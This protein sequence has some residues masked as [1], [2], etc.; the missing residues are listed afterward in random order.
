[1]V[2]ILNFGLWF[3]GVHVKAQSVP[4]EHL[5]HPVPAANPQ[6]GSDPSEVHRRWDVSGVDGCAVPLPSDPWGWYIIQIIMRWNGHLK[7]F[8]WMDLFGTG[9]LY[10]I[11]YYTFISAFVRACKKRFKNIFHYIYIDL[12][13]ACA[14]SRSIDRSWQLCCDVNKWACTHGTKGFIF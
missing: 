13:A 4:A 14:N 3:T 8:E 10:I 5:R 12:F 2:F 11:R 1:M 9:E 7:T 6:K